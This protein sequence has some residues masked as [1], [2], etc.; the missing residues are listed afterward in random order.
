[1]TLDL[2]LAR[3]NMVSNQ[4][5]TWEVLDPRV[6]DVLGSVRRE[7]FVRPDLEGMAYA[8][9]ELPIGH[10]EIMMK[11]VLEGRLL[12]ALA[13][14]GG[15][16]VLEIGT[17]SGYLTAC[18]AQLAARVTSVDIHADFTGSAMA[19]LR[20]LGIDNCELLT[21]EALHG[22]MPAEPFDAIAVTGAVARLPQH[23]TGWLKPGGRLF[24]VQGRAPVMQAL[25]LRQGAAEPERI[26]PLFETD[27]PYLRHAAPQTQ[28]VL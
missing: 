20:G 24:V 27:L 21:A 12:Q 8:D 15:E 18:L 10:G 22:F 11:P 28:F 16:H 6:L 19:R 7:L 9:L 23:W 25:L 4:V 26:E 17:G 13:L 2:D 1:M 14:E 3:R 5:R